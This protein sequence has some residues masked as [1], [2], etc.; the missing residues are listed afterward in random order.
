MAFENMKLP[1]YP[2]E[3]ASL[4]ATNNEVAA[5]QAARTGEAIYCEILIWLFQKASHIVVA[6]RKFK[7]AK[8]YI[9]IAFG[10]SCIGFW[11]RC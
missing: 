6:T 2:L 7:H 1:A 9:R 11:S 10:Y 5:L 4:E 3:V 8:R